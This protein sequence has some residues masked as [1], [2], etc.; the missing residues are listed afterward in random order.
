MKAALCRSYIGAT[1]SLDRAPDA[2]RLLADRQAVGKVVIT[3]DG[4]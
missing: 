2:L 3:V 1:F 4:P